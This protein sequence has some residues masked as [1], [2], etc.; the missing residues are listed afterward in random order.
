MV[1]V[2]ATAVVV[3]AVGVLWVEVMVEVVV[4]KQC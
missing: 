3:V 2:D 4:N 1:V